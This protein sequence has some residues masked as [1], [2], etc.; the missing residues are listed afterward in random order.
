MR[1]ADLNPKLS[2][3]LDAGTLRFDCP[4]PE[5]GH[6]IRVPLGTS[7]WRASGEFPDGLTVIPSIN[8]A[9]LTLSA[10]VAALDGCRWHGNITNGDVSTVP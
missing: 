8:A 1:L 6:K 3:S 2:G 5:H 7:Y 10:N 9:N 4:I